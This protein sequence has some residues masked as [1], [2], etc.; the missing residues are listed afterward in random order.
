MKKSLSVRSVTM[1]VLDVRFDKR[2]QAKSIQ[3][4]NFPIQLWR[5]FCSRNWLF[6]PFSNF[7][8]LQ[9]RPAAAESLLHRIIG[10]ILFYLGKVGGIGAGSQSHIPTR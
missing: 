6:F 2:D 3:I 4:E 9:R 1:V 10:G 8:P 7:C 5:I